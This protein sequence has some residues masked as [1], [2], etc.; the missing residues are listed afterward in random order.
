VVLEEAPVVAAGDGSRGVELLVLSGKTAEAVERMGL[1]L[2]EHLSRAEGVE[3]ADVAWTLQVGRLG[4]G[5]RRAVVCGG[6]E[7]AVEK[8]GGRGWEERGWVSGGEPPVVFMFP[9]QG[10]Q[11]VNMGRELYDAGGEYR[12]VVEGCGEELRRRWGLDLVGL[13]YP[14]VEAAG[15][16]ERLK[17]TEVAQVA[18]YVVEYALARQWEA[19]GVRAESVVGHSVGEYVAAT[20]AGVM[21][22][23]EAL[24]LV[25]MR[26]R[27]MQGQEPGV[28]VA[29]GLG[30]AEA[31]GLVSRHEGVWLAAVNGPQASVLSGRAAEVER[32][33]AEL[34]EGGIWVKRLETSH[35]FHS[36]LMEGVV[37]GMVREVKGVEL[38]EPQRGYVSGLT[39]SWVRVGE[40]TRPEYWGRQLREPV[41][42]GAGVQALLG[43]AERVYLE[44]GPGQGLSGLLR[45][46]AGAG[47]GGVVASGLGAG[48]WRGLWRSVGRLWCAGVGVDWRALRQG[49]R[50]RRVVLPTY[51]F[52]RQRYW[53]E[54]R[55]AAEPAEVV[56]K[57]PDPGEWLYAPL[58]KQTPPPGLAKSGGSTPAQERWL[59]LVDESGLGRP[60]ADA[61]R[62]RGHTVFTAVSGPGYARSGE[63]SWV[64]NYTAREDYFRLVNEIGPV[65]VVHLASLRLPS[66]GA[67]GDGA[68]SPSDRRDF[69]SLVYLAQACLARAGAATQRIDVIAHRA[70]KVFPSEVIDPARAMLVAP[71]LVLPQEYPH[72]S[73]R[74]VDVDL[75][76]ET[77]VGKLATTLVEELRREGEEPFV[78]YRQGQRWARTYEPIQLAGDGSSDGSGAD[79]L[80]PRGVYLIT[81]GLGG[82]GLVLAEHLARRVQGRLVL[83]GRTGMITADRWAEWLAT[84]AADD[85]TSRRIRALQQLE[86]AG[87]EVCCVQADVAVREEMESAIAR[88]KERFGTIHGVIHAAGVVAPTAVPDALPEICELQ[89]RPKVEGLA[90][91]AEVLRAER[92]DFCLV[93]SSLASVLGGLGLV[94]YA[95]ANQFMDAFVQAQNQ[96]SAWPWITVNWDAW[97]LGAPPQ[98]VRSGLAELAMTPAE[99]AAVFD[100]ILRAGYRGQVIVSTANLAARRKQ[101]LRPGT[102]A[103][104]VGAGS[105][106]E[107]RL[108][109][110]PPLQQPYVAPSND[111]E[112]QLAAIW[113]ELLGVEPVGVHDDFF[114]L[115]GHSLLATQMLSRLRQRLGVELSLRDLFAAPT[116]SGL[117]AVIRAALPADGQPVAASIARLAPG[118]ERCLSFGQERLWFFAQLSPASSAY[119]LQVPCRLDGEIDEGALDYALQEVVRRHEVLR[120]NF[121][122]V[123]GSP[124]LV[125]HE[126][127][128][129][130]LPV[131]RFEAGDEEELQRQRLRLAGEQK[132][133][134]FDLATGPLLRARLVRWGPRAATLL[135]TFHHIVFD[136]WSIKVLFRELREIYQARLRGQSCPLPDLAIQYSDFAYWQRARLQ[137][138]ALQRE[139]D[140]WRGQLRGLAVLDLP[141]D[142]PRPAVQTFRGASEVVLLPLEVTQALGTLCQQEGVTLFMA[143]LAAFKVLLSR[144]TGQEDVAVGSPIAGRDRAETEGLIGFFLNTLVLRTDLAGNPTFR[145]LLGRERQVAL[146]A[147]AHQ[148]VPF[149]KLVEELHPQRDL[150]R[151]PLFQVVFNFLNLADRRPRAH[152]DEWLGL[153]EQDLEGPAAS[154]F[155]LTLYGL[156][157]A[158]GI[159]LAAAYNAD[160]FRAER[161]REYLAQLQGLIAQMV[162][163]PGER[164][165]DYTLV[166]AAAERV[167]PQPGAFPPLGGSV[168]VVERFEAQALRVPDRMAVVDGVRAW[169]YAGLEEASNQ[170]AN[171]LIARGLGRGDVVAMLAERDARLVLALLGVL[172][173]GAGFTILDGTY[174]VARLV[175]SLHVAQPKGWIQFSAETPL[176]P[177]LEA[178]VRSI[179]CRLVLEGGPRD[180]ADWRACSTAAPPL[181]A[182]PDDRAYLAFTSGST[183]EPKAIIGTHRPLA[184]FLDWHRERFGLNESDRFSLL[185]GLA[186]DPLLR[187]IF[188]PLSLGATL[189]VPSRDDLSPGRLY[190]W[191]RQRGITVVHLTPAMGMMLAEPADSVQADS[192]AETGLALRY[193]FF[194][195]DVLRTADVARLK[196][197]APAV[198]CVNFYGT[199]ETPQAMGCFIVPDEGSVAATAIADSSELP[200]RS[201]AGEVIP[202]GR[203]IRDVD[204]LVL[205]PAHRLCGIGELGEIYVRTP[206]LSAGYLRDPAL[207]ESRFLPDGFAPGSTARMYR[208]GDLGRCLPDGNVIF[209][210]RGDR[211]IKVR[212]FRVE[213]EEIE[214]ALRRH[215]QVREAVAVLRGESPGTERLVAYY[216]AAPGLV[217]GVSELRHGLRGVLPEHMI[218]A[219][220]MALK[221]L[222]LTPNGKIDRAALPAPEGWRPE[223]GQAYLEPRSQLEQ[224]MAAIWREV[225]GLEKVGIHDSFFD[226]GGHSLLVVKVHRLMRERLGRELS[227]VDLFKYPTIHDLAAH[228]ADEAPPSDQNDE[229]EARARHERDARTRRRGRMQRLRKEPA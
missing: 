208:T 172:K 171:C 206:Y 132:E 188:T 54:R 69:H 169:T 39:G 88:A 182:G 23:K 60:V 207:T 200:N 137:G 108:H 229:I 146:D 192:D 124:C 173:A 179:G 10:V 36:G 102:T 26:G 141:T 34:A 95:A 222:P 142:F 73:C 120:T 162:Q 114:E 20:V 17:Q 46:G 129:V 63:H 6:V 106:G 119:N 111:P 104:P 84:H 99:G 221:T 194:G 75:P 52:D 57:R 7:E 185:A 35:G 14:E 150:S 103:A 71:C 31:L 45:Q 76:E 227:L 223:L 9:G 190:D 136:G 196:R 211:Q 123:D 109:A 66:P 140:F 128:R 186:H 8:L 144:H 134:P 40:V 115:G 82:V 149:E 33:A 226:L 224:G 100:Q 59:L 125:V 161:V 30:E 11:R 159:S 64:I 139:L 15:Q 201:S 147:F 178:S 118:T 22:W 62:E 38:R 2:S 78:A 163:N 48:G 56:A 212:G 191:S 127:V 167:L 228:L 215:P 42:F 41:R 1:N 176:P 203:G 83:V 58:W 198:C 4:F 16:A 153:S 202:I 122:T 94:A 112:A 209:V 193:A 68:S 51:P 133:Q 81:G 148:A 168:G 164:I 91:L 107:S 101:W 210:G 126:T 98:S 219:A 90:V 175:D 43:G 187:D 180:E 197:V 184:H 67:S 80:R 213:L 155:D 217:P 19:W 158:S 110:R 138:E 143:L 170:L 92:L 113:Q 79:L 157:T 220:F 3:L 218:P 37:E 204:L 166:T 25:V 55:K 174:P 53:I 93:T 216:V 87:A 49:E 121:V 117:S 154:K 205:T 189:Y 135:L 151:T 225:L 50:R 61:L 160:L 181:T 152:E 131:S 85:P 44:V 165:R 116:V 74:C 28:M 156:E 13:L 96:H 130:D 29:V 183:G 32:C 177:A 5:H 21:G 65:R 27:L 214:S 199:T 195:G 145:E 47:W 77:A 105:A 89:F 72:V 18:I 12:A 97:Q 86:E 24:G 70:Q